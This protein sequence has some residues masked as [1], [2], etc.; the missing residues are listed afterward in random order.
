M[1]G[2]A[3]WLYFADGATKDSTTEQVGEEQVALTWKVILRTGTWK[4]RPGPG[5]M[6]LKQPLKVYRDKAPKGHLSMAEIKKNFDDG[7]VEY[8]TAPILHADG[9][10]DNTGYVRKLAIQ[11]VAGED[12]SKAKESLLWAGFE[13]TEP[14]I[15]GKIERKTIPSVS[16]GVL[17]DYEHPETGVKYNQVLAH[18]MLTNKP[19]INKTGEFKKALPEGVMASEP[20]DLPTEAAFFDDGAPADAEVDPSK[21]ETPSAGT[22]VW[23]TDD[24]FA[25]IKG[26]L[27]RALDDRR[28]ALMASFGED[29]YRLDYPYY[30]VDDVQGNGASGKA[31]ICSGYGH[32]RE[33]W[34]GNYT[35][36]EGEVAIEAF[37][38]WT[39]ARPEWVAASETPTPPAPSAAPTPAHSPARPSQPESELRRAQQR[40]TERL[41][42]SRPTTT[43]EGGTRMG[44][45]TDLLAQKG[46]EL[47]DEERA[48]ITAQ[49]EETERLR[50]DNER[51]RLS[52]QEE[53]A[54]AFLAELKD[55]PF[56]NP[57][58]LKYIDTVFMSDDGAPAIELSEDLGNGRRSQPE[59]KS[60]TEILTGLFATL[61]KDEKGKITLSAQ[62]TRLPDDPKPP[63][64]ALKDGELDE[65]KTPQ[66]RA[67]EQA[68]EF[69]AQ[70]LDLPGV[71]L[72]A[73]NGG[74]S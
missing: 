38:N 7:V 65:T 2:S 3:I 23:K 12:G 8:V 51:L 33:S 55:T 72:A 18:V 22:V 31:L 28:R 41:G 56:D 39:P 10:L 63:K 52:D 29:R 15:A 26:K 44:L 67:D 16:A 4:L 17:F 36:T 71:K 62:A 19:W 25:W 27:Q 35:F 73:T 43:T 24:G 20:D 21:K 34:V 69:A 42:L 30:S 53:S 5:G 70:G 74:G 54:K 68:A 64:E 58:T 47:S 59:N 50:Q 14:D 13:I 61:P 57:G 37:Q 45:L 6:K 49:E 66:Q 60:A 32:D 40:R 48:T 46:V 1:T 11:D 9:T